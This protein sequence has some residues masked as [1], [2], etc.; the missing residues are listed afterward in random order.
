[1][2][3]KE[4]RSFSTFYERRRSEYPIRFSDRRARGRRERVEQVVPERRRLPYQIRRNERD[5]LK[6]PAFVVMKGQEGPA[7]TMDIG[8]GGIRVVCVKPIPLGS[9]LQLNFSFGENF[10]YVNVAG[11][12]VYCQ[13]TEGDPGGQSVNVIGIRIIGIKFVD[14]EDFVI[15]FLMRIEKALKRS[16]YSEEK[17]TL[18]ITQLDME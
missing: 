2:E 1:M 13:N 5:P 11:E 7:C 18:T 4:S 6:I 8:R 9:P 3:N 16:R 17:A 14:V 12:V 15:K 10:C